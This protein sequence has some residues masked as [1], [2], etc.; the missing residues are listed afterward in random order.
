MGGKVQA[1]YL[2]KNL[3]LVDVHLQSVVDLV[4]DVLVHVA[5]LQRLRTGNEK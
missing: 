5:H 3:L 2:A 4:E 1:E